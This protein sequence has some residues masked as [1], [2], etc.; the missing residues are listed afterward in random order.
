MS[1]FI[2]ICIYFLTIKLSFTQFT[3]HFLAY[4]NHSGSANGTQRKWD[5]FALS[6]L[7]H[8]LSLSL[9]QSLSLSIALGVLGSLMEQFGR[10]NKVTSGKRTKRC[11]CC[12]CCTRRVASVDV[13]AVAV[14][15]CL[16]STLFTFD[17]EVKEEEGKL[18]RQQQQ[19]QPC[20]P[21]ATWANRSF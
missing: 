16:L 2:Y 9:T 5:T 18:K 7:S 3:F 6:L 4:S 1:V 17:A 10:R 15:I 14:A 21:E 11:K 20:R 19:Q 8:S 12:S 13:V